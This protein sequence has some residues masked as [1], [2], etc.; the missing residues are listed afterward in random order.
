MG[1]IGLSQDQERA[2][3][4]LNDIV[5]M[6]QLERPV[7]MALA[8]DLLPEDIDSVRIVSN[9]ELSL[10][11]VEEIQALLFSQLHGGSNA[12]L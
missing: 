6:V 11:Q 9:A 10:D 1:P 12:S 8:D 5:N 3:G 2:T 7:Q 4:F